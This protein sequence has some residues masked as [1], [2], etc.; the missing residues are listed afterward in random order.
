MGNNRM[1]LEAAEKEL[2]DGHADL[3]AFGR[4][5]IGNPDLVERLRTGADL[6]E[7][8]EKTYY[9]GDWHGYSDWPGLTGPVALKLSL[10][11][12]HCEP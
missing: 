3:F 7:A 12:R 9:G 8:P 4:P 2:A 10:S 11:H 1:T 5:F 6:V